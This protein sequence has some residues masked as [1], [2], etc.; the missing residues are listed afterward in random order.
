[1][2]EQLP[3]AFASKGKRHPM[4]DVLLFEHY[5]PLSAERP[6]NEWA[7]NLRALG[8]TRDHLLVTSE[9]FPGFLLQQADPSL[10][11]ALGEAPCWTLL[12]S[13]AETPESMLRGRGEDKPFAIA[14]YVDDVA[15]PFFVNLSLS[16]LLD[17]IES[18]YAQLRDGARSQH[19]KLRGRYA[20]RLQEGLITLSL[21]ISALARDVKN[22]HQH[23][24]WRHEAKFTMVYAPWTGVARE[25]VDYNELL[26]EQQLQTAADL[27]EADKD[28][29]D[30][31]TAVSA[32]GASVDAFRV[33]R[34]AL[35]VVAATLLLTAVILVVTDVGD[36][37]IWHWLADH[38]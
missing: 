6:S 23:G 19:R 4:L 8:V 33:S 5:S 34:L 25:P 9:S 18:S 24:W 30:V 11:P 27:L 20:E 16:Q 7:G 35:W 32:L 13:L 10:C 1:M 28:Y 29:R 15:G 21:D 26:A 12:G 14:G 2:A 36:H 22:V 3:G 31:L 37:T 17:E 38:L